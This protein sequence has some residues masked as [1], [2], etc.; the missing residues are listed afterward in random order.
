LCV[1]YTR[2]RGRREWEGRRSRKRAS[3]L[4]SEVACG[5]MPVEG[6]R[7]EAQGRAAKGAPQRR[8]EGDLVGGDSRGRIERRR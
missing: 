2:V 1:R 3:D 6:E 7:I 8:Q 5:G 4:A